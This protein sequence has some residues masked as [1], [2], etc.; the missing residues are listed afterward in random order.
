MKPPVVFEIDLKAFTLALTVPPEDLESSRVD[1]SG[2]PHPEPAP[3]RASSF[4]NY[5]VSN[6]SPGF[7]VATELGVNFGNKLFSS[8]YFRD[9]AGAFHR[10]RTYVL[11][12]DIKD[13]RRTY[14][15]DAVAFGGALGGAFDVTGFSVARNYALNPNGIRQNLSGISGSVATPSTADVY[16]NGQLVRHEQLSPGQFT[17]ENLPLAPGDNST[18]IVIRDAFGREQVITRPFYQAEDLLRKGTN[19]YEFDIGRAHRTQLAG[20]P[21]G[22]AALERFDYGLTSGVTVGA[23]VESTTALTSGDVNGVF[24][25]PVGQLSARFATSHDHGLSGGA[26]RIAYLYTSRY[27]GFS[28]FSQRQSPF[29]ATISQPAVIDRATL[30]QGVAANLSI[31]RVGGIAVQYAQQRFRDQLP[32]HALT[33]TAGGSVSRLGYLTVSV[34][35]RDEHGLR[36]PT[37][38][39]NF[40]YVLGRD[41]SVSYATQSTPNGSDSSVVVQKTLTERTGLAYRLESSAGNSSGRDVDVLY[42]TPFANIELNDQRVPGTN[43]APT[44][45]L[46][47][48]LAFVGKD[49]FLTQPVSGG[50]AEVDLHGLSH[51]RVLANGVDAGRT[52]GRGKLLVSELFPYQTN[53]VSISGEDA[54]LNYSIQSTDAYIVPPDRGGSTMNF[55]VHRLQAFTGLLAVRTATAS[56]IPTFGIVTLVANGKSSTFDIGGNGAFYFE[57]IAPG[58]YAAKIQYRGGQCSFDIVIPQADRDIVSLGTLTCRAEA[59]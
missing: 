51:I 4:L 56:V 47:G 2:R 20:S 5:A 32:S 55:D 18:R 40:T 43:R 21:A 19:D 52:D 49:F 26:Y 45:T 13:V 3:R 48:G 46:S 39:A 6:G 1:L 12:D 7:D 54:P 57:N 24:G 50:F 8:T 33:A 42:K 38:G 31:G 11:I 34:G 27:A 23:R 37:F 16:I 58:R 17:L 28:V 9:A 35:H 29:Y 22:L 30:D 44:V 36:G 53:Q 15:G 10:G 14:I 59:K 25:L 41:R